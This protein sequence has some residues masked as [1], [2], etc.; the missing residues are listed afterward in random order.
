MDFNIDN[1]RHLIFFTQRKKIIDIY[2][3]K[4]K[5]GAQLGVTLLYSRFTSGLL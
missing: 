5:I 2:R 4:T 1:H 3:K